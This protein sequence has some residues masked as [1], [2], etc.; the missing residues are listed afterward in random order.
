MIDTTRGLFIWTPLWLK[1][2]LVLPELFR[3]FH[4]LIEAKHLK[5]SDNQETRSLFLL[6]KNKK[7]NKQTYS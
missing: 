4:V 3:P 6:G 7:K 1:K 5:Q 2:R